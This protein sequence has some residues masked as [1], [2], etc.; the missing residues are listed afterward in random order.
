MPD[1]ER[2][3]GSRQSGEPTKSYAIFVKYR[4]LKPYERSLIKAART[5]YGDDYRSSR[6]RQIQTW[7]SRWGWVERAAEWDNYLDAQGR[8]AQVEEIKAMRRRHAQVGVAMLN[9]VAARLMGGQVPVADGQVQLVE[10]LD[11]NRLGVAGLA[12]LADIGVKIERMARG[13]PDVIEETR[14]KVGA[15]DQDMAVAMLADPALAA[16]AAQ[17]ASALDT[18]AAE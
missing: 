2:E 8:A 16:L 14:L 13:E 17:L 5:Y 9:R 10:A 18:V 3:P 12:R 7:S 6:L 4:D 11:T 15:A 1:D